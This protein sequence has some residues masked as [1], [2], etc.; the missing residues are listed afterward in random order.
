MNIDIL[1]PRQGFS[2]CIERP[3]DASAGYQVGG[4]WKAPSGTGNQLFNDLRFCKS[5]RSCIV[6][7]SFFKSSK[8]RVLSGLWISM[9]TVYQGN[10]LCISARRSSERRYVSESQQMGVCVI[11]ISPVYAATNAGS[12]VIKLG[13]ASEPSHAITSQLGLIASAA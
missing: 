13:M 5:V 7:L 6:S 10:C 8:V 1:D 12:G 4:I 3:R 11:S 9:F 2:L